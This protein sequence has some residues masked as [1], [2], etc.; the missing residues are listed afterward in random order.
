MGIDGLWQ[1]AEETGFA[2]RLRGTATMRSMTTSTLLMAT[3]VLP[4]LW[5]WMVGTVGSRWWGVPETPPVAP[6]SLTSRRLTDY[7]I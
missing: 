6:A 7:E 4:A 2:A 1:S 5:G 3:F